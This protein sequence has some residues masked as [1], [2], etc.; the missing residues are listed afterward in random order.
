MTSRAPAIVVAGPSGSGK[1]S[2][3]PVSAFGVDWFNVD[4]RAA[5]LNDG[6]YQGIPPEAR[7]LAQAECEAFVAEHIAAGQSYAVET[8]LRSTAAI[9]QARQARAAG[10]VTLLVFVST[11]DPLENE[12]R[13]T[14][15]AL[16]G[17]HAAQPAEIREIYSCSMASL[18][19]AVEVFERVELWDN[20]S[21]GRAPTLVAARA[22]DRWRRFV[23]ELPRWAEFTA[24]R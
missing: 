5:E 24:S 7:A 4:D 17:G 22:G 23:G 8:T 12:R 3:F 19:D 14:L 1:S 11:D 15:R 20:S 10:F 18:R 21:F 13:V 2:V 9:D 6:S 16:S